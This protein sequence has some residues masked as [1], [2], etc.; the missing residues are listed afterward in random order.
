MKYYSEILKKM[1]DT[2]KELV[3]AEKKSSRIGY[4]KL[5]LSN[6]ISELARADKKLEEETNRCVEEI[7]EEQCGEILDEI[8][9]DSAVIKD[10]P[11]LQIEK[12]KNLVS[13][14]E[15][16]K[17][18]KDSWNNEDFKVDWE[19]FSKLIDQIFKDHE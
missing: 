10:S 18:V 16:L 8:F 19:G 11:A 7:G 13:N 3:E 15:D 1:F 9:E 17:K 2:E 5:C 4:W 12:K 6:A 14:K